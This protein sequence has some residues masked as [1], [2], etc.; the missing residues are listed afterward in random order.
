[1]MLYNT[2]QVGDAMYVCVMK[3]H[4]AYDV[5]AVDVSSAAA[6]AE[7]PSNTVERLH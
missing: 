3:H 5:N 4:H 6:L 1:M 7:S 2:C